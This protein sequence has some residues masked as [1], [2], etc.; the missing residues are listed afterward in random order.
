MGDRVVAMHQPNFIPWLGFFYKLARADIFILVD[1]IQFSAKN[2]TNRAGVRSNERAMWLTVPVEHHFG[3]LIKD[4]AIVRTEPWR[5]NHLAILR[6]CYGK[7]PFFDE[8]FPLVEKWYGKPYDDRLAVF[9]EGIIRNVAEILGLHTEI[10]RSSALGCAGAKTDLILCLARSVGASVY[11]SGQGG[12]N[13]QDEQEFERAGI[14]L[15]Y[16]DFV[17]PV[18]QQRHLPFIAGLSILDMLFSCGPLAVREVLHARSEPAR[19]VHPGEPSSAAG[20]SQGLNSAPQRTC[21]FRRR[22]TW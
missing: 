15:H 21:A 19:M 1:S 11:L 20:L 5:A 7:Y 13:Y 9:N 4:V 17:H 8:I 10:V 6:G 16:S 14:G 2:Y 18:Y 3:Q 12:A 22:E